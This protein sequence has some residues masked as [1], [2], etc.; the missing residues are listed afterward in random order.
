M[1]N[2]KSGAGSLGDATVNPGTPV[3]KSKIAGSSGISDDGGSN[4]LTG[5][6]IVTAD[7]MDAAVTMAKG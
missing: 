4:P 6:S 1:S 2:W 5:L 7:N 3:G